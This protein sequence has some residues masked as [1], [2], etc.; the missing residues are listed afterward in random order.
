MIT[1][2]RTRSSRSTKDFGHSKPLEAMDTLTIVPAITTSTHMHESDC[3]SSHLISV[4]HTHSTRHRTRPVINLCRLFRSTDTP[5]EGEN[6]KAGIL[7][8]QASVFPTGKGSHA[9]MIEEGREDCH[10]LAER[11][12]HR[13]AVNAD[14]YEFFS[15]NVNPTR[16]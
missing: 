13:A 14:S 9:Y 15:E 10:D 12:P 6:S 3:E 4:L 7:V 8:Q 11:S 5:Y 1:R 16:E 2:L